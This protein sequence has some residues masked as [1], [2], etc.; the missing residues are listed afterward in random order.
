[1]EIFNLQDRSEFIDEVVLLEYDEWADNRDYNR[2][3]RI[4]KK[5]K[6]IIDLFSNRSFCK[7]ILVNNATLIGFISLFPSDC[8]EFPDLTPWYATIYVKSEYRGRGYSKVL[9]DAILNEARQRGFN[10]L[11]LKTELDNYYEKIGAK[12]LQM[13]NETEKLYKIDL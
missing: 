8:L 13:I 5:K 12:Y 11:Y 10:T 1:M 3:E 2:D 9:S 6:K 4:D 7:L